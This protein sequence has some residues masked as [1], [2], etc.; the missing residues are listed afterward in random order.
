M[1][2]DDK[3]F[4]H[5]SLQDRE[6]IVRYL[7]A[8]GEGIQNGKLVLSSNG[9]SLSLDAPELVKLDVEARQEPRQSML[10]LKISWKRVGATKRLG[11]EPLCIAGNAETSES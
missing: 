5:E 3:R 10:M 4:E 6:S 1:S 2:G 7:A 8:L 11:V 9:T